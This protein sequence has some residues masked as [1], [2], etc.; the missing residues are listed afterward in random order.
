MK[1]LIYLFLA[2]FLFSCSEKRVTLD[3]LS[4]TGG[5]FYFEGKKFTGVGFEMH[6]SKQ[7]AHEIR[8][9]DG[10]KDGEEKIYSENGDLIILRTYKKDEYDGPFE[11]YYETDNDSVSIESKGIYK[12]GKIDG[13]YISCIDCNYDISPSGEKSFKVEK[14]FVKG[15]YINGVRVGKFQY[16][17]KSN[18]NFSV[19]NYDENGKLIQG[20]EINS[21]NYDLFI[22]SRIIY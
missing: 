19:V 14:L 11:S 7:V 3:E 21:S 20:V 6:N 8:Y 13:E 5:Y 10:Y 9:K 2:T 17:T 1:N 16:Y 22:D 18:P 12:N 4:K 15:N